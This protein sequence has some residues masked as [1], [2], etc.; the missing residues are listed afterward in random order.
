VGPADK[1]IL[2]AL[3]ALYQRINT[4]GGVLKDANMIERWAKFSEHSE[5]GENCQF[6]KKCQYLF[7]KY[8]YE[9]IRKLVL[10]VLDQIK[11]IDGK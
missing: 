2:S 4:H 11:I 6:A 10:E 3:W 9:D 1:N 8:D 7:E 5:A